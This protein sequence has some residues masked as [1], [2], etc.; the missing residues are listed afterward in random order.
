LIKSRRSHRREMKQRRKGGGVGLLG[1]KQ[2]GEEEEPF[3]R[4][5]K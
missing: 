4:G 1:N 3:T 2:L 5:K